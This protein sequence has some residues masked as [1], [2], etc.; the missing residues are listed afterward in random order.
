[1]ITQDDII[2]A[3]QQIHDT[4]SQRAF[5]KMY[6][7]F[8]AQQHDYVVEGYPANYYV[9]D[10]RGEHYTDADG[11][12]VSGVT[13]EKQLIDAKYRESYENMV[14]DELDGTMPIKAVYD[15]WFAKVTQY[16]L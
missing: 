7:E 8:Q 16:M 9:V 1:M 2:A 13:I 12:T 6:F 14:I 15:E 5:H 11:N 10:E 4:E 3:A